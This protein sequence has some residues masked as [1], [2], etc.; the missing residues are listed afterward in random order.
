MKEYTVNTVK[1]DNVFGVKATW[2]KDRE[3]ETQVDYFN[4]EKEAIDHAQWWTNKSG[5]RNHI[6]S[7]EVTQVI[8]YV[9]AK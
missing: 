1:S 5:Q 3:H 6:V 8:R 7:V 2:S 9:V 4:N